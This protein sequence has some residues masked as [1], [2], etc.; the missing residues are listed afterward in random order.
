MTPDRSAADLLTPEA[1][2]ARNADVHADM[3]ALDWDA[4]ERR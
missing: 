1:V 3:R 4:E 2:D